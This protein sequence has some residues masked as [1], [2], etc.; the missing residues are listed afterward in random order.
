EYEGGQGLISRVIT[1]SGS[2]EFHGS[3]NY[4]AQ[5]DGLVADN[6][7]LADA[8]FDTFDTAFTLGG[9]IIRDRLWFFGSLQRKE[10]DEDVI[11]PNTQSVLRSVN[12]TEDLGFAKITWQATDN[13]KVIA[14]FFND[15]TD[16]SGSFNTSTRPNRDL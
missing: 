9:P 4:Y 5:S 2:N 6:K 11:D 3:I 7:H 1:K 10:R 8:S 12:R 14:E 16:I 15:P 13:D